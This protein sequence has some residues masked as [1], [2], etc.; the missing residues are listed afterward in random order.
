MAKPTTGKRV[1]E[2]GATYLFFVGLGIYTLWPWL[3]GVRP[4]DPAPRT[5][6]VYGFSILQEVMS[7]RIFPAFQ[8]YWEQQHHER[9]QVLGSFSGSG[10]TTNHILMGAPAQVALLAIEGDARRLKEH[11]LA[12][13]D[14]ET[15]PCR[16]VI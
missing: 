4:K 6:V 11:G 16:G 3:A 8:H 12:R 5:L 15:F 9:V 2:I 13:T 7:A 1:L 14:W 10:T